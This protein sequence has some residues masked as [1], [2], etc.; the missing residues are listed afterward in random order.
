MK[1]EKLSENEEPLKRSTIKRKQQNNININVS[2]HIYNKIIDFQN[3][4]VT[5]YDSLKSLVL[6]SILK[7]IKYLETKR[8]IDILSRKIANLVATQ[9]RELANRYLKEMYRKVKGNG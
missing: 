8:E 7:E 9:K 5:E 2:M 6:Q 4:D 3:S 1:I